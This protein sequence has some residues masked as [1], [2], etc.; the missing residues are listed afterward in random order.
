LRVIFNRLQYDG[1]KNVVLL[2]TATP[3]N[4]VDHSKLV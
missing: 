4:S 2:A 1:R 3:G